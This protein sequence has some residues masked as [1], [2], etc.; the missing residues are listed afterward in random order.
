MNAVALRYKS[1]L[2]A[3]AARAR[4][5]GQGHARG[6]RAAATAGRAA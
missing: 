6:V 1:G 2:A 5:R 4:G 3:E